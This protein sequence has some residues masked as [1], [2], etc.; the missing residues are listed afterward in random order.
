MR[1]IKK[2]TTAQLTGFYC[3]FC[4]TVNNIYNKIEKFCIKAMSIGN[5][6]PE[7]TAVVWR[8]VMASNA[9]KQLLNDVEWG[10]IRFFNYR[11]SSRHW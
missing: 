9:I 8:G 7:D 4:Q 2:M 3:A 1:D 6:V 11:S 5:M 10:G